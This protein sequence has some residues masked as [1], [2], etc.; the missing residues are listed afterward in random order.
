MSSFKHA[1]N[2]ELIASSAFSR[3]GRQNK[4]L[5]MFSVSLTPATVESTE[6]P[7]VSGSEEESVGLRSCLLCSADCKMDLMPYVVT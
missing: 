5:L 3:I 7:S 2:C 1:Q 4:N 6:A